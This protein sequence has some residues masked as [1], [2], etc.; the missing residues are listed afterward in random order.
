VSPRGIYPL[1]SFFTGGT[2]SV[3]GESTSWDSVKARVKEIVDEEDKK[4]PLNDDVI[5]AG[6]QAEGIEV[7]R[8]TIAKYRRQLNI[9]T[10]P[11]AEARLV[12]SRMQPMFR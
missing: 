8:R 3:D 7:S 5:A 10:A 6:L 4:N 12:G 9:P 1:R 11:L 2:E